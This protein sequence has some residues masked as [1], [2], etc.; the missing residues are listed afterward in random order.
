MYKCRIYFC[1][2]KYFQRRLTFL[3]AVCLMYRMILSERK[4]VYCSD[5]FFSYNNIYLRVYNNFTLELTIV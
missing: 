4:H 2:S 3:D 1:F 5:V